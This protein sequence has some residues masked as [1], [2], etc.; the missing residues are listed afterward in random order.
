MEKMNIVFY[1]FAGLAFFLGMTSTGF[2]I[3]LLISVRNL[4]IKIGEIHDSIQ[5]QHTKKY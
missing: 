5:K 3:L 4:E 2:L 1:V